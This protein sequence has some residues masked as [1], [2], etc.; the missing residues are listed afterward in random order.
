MCS[1][2]MLAG[3]TVSAEAQSFLDSVFKNHLTPLAARPVTLKMLA[4]EFERNNN[5]LSGGYF[6]LYTRACLMRQ[7]RFQPLCLASASASRTPPLDP[8]TA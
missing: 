5:Q 4:N 8:S 3:Q 7:T 6:Q 1:A 2:V